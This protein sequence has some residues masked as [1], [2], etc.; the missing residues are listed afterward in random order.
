MRTKYIIGGISIIA[1]S[2][3]F[4]F[5]QYQKN[6]VLENESSSNNAEN[7]I[8]TSTSTEDIPIKEVAQTSDV[9]VKK[10]SYTVEQNQNAELVIGSN[11][12]SFQFEEGQTIYEVMQK[13][14]EENKLSFTGKEYPALGFFVTS[15][16]SLRSGEGKNLIYYVN[17][18]EASVG[19]SN[20]EIKEGDIIEWKL[21]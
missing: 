3:V 8:G 11:K 21:E 5:F 15:V 19:I 13:L 2:C 18:K 14:Q 9:S 12:V 6:V 4:I 10:D 20:Y 7:L 1:L 17:G 16:D